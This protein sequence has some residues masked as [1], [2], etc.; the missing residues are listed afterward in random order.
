MIATVHI[1]CMYVELK[2]GLEYEL[3]TPSAS[4]EALPITLL[5]Y[6]SSFPL[7]SFPINYIPSQRM[8]VSLTHTHAH[9]HAGL[10][11]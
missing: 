4:N 7:F 8:S 5:V 6:C 10:G 11:K 1:L 3:A 2:K 9:N